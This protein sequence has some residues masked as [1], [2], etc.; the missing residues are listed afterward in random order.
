MFLITNSTHARDYI[1]TASIHLKQ[2][3]KFNK[4]FEY[5]WSLAVVFGFW[6]LVSNSLNSGVVDYSK[7][8]RKCEKMVSTTHNNRYSNIKLEM[9]TFPCGLVE[10]STI[11]SVALFAM[12][13]PKNVAFNICV[14][15]GVWVEAITVCEVLSNMFSSRLNINI[16]RR[17]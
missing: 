11:N 1:W 10:Q 6:F 7:T 16:F 5:C 3:N 12:N 13:W 4:Q 15:V 2:M 9:Y 17:N 14:C 8:R